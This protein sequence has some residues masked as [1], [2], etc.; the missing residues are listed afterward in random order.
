M[1]KSFELENI[2]GIGNGVHKKV[3]ELDILPNKPSLLIAPNGF[4]KSSFSTAFKALNRDRIK[5]DSRDFYK[6]NEANKPKLVLKYKP[7]D[8][9]IIELL[10]DENSNT[11]SNHFDYFVISNQV[12]AKGVGQSFGGRTNVSASL[13]I[14]PIVLIDTVPQ[15]V[16][17][18]YSFTDEK[19]AFG[20]LGK[21]LPNLTAILRKQ[22][23]FVALKSDENLVSLNRTS[24]V[25]V[26]TRIDAFVHRIG[27]LP[28]TLS[29]DELLA[30]IEANELNF[31]SSTPYLENI[32]IVVL[33]FDLGLAH[34]KVIESYLV[35][36][37]LIKLYNADRVRFKS[38]CERKEYEVD[39][40][41]YISL[42]ADLNST[43]I[44]FKPKETQ[45]SL[46]LEF[47][48]AHLI[49]NGQRDVLSFMALL[50][51]A[52]KKF[53]KQKC[54][55]IIDEVFDYLDDAN[56]VAVQYYTTQ[57]IEE[58]KV[59]NRQ[60]YPL[61]LTH[62]DPAY[63]KGYVFGSKHKLK[64]YHLSKVQ[65]TTSPH[66]VKILKER[67]KAT[68]IVKG[69][70]E[71]LLLHYHPTQINRRADFE[72]L[73][74]RP[75]WGEEANFDN[76]LNEEVQKYC[77]DE[78]TFDPLAVCCA[79]RKNIERKIYQQIAE[80]GHREIFL[81]EK[82]SGTNEKL[83]YAESI[84]VPVNESFYF[85]GLIYNEALH[86]KED[87]DDNSNIAPAFGK[88]RNLTIKKLIKSCFN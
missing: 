52:R 62:L 86:W 58:F 60:L 47:P 11:I 34:H 77:N 76:F 39:K 51:K 35:A 83:E 57:L 38:Y 32:S 3:F 20:L 29:R 79:V 41:H 45:G 16:T 2:K 24:N 19:N 81:N 33:G 75:T 12:R 1:I 74:L 87:R 84:G 73:N 13:N 28:A 88:L 82:V 14:D 70:I 56:L 72:G 36:I 15:N 54:I 23:L 80:A 8:E 6:E 53:K 42:F 59:A 17:L 40:E 44:E 61:I 26:R 50:E 5:L 85:L 55:L 48:K 69:D 67:N 71:K 65:A 31:L 22:G 4:G 37:Q 64:V 21:I 68:S 10:A 46:V 25:G 18:Q 49:S 9:D 66:L 78:N 63:F 27:L 7:A 30:H 43:W